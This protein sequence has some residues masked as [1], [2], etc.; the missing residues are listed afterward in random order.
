MD[1]RTSRLLQK[2]IYIAQSKY[3]IKNTEILSII[4]KYRN[5]KIEI[6]PITLCLHL[7]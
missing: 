5:R 1:E 3:P 2:I 6:H 7:E 4:V